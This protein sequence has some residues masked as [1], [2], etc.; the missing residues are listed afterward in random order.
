M[1]AMI[2]LQLDDPD[3][4]FVGISEARREGGELR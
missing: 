1:V 4:L 2:T 3:L